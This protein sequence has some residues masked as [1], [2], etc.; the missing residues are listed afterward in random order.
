MNMVIIYIVV[1]AS[2]Q[3]LDVHK[4]HLLVMDPLQE[5][6]RKLRVYCKNFKYGLSCHLLLK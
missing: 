6:S 2:L 1:I 3:I 5:D 4:K